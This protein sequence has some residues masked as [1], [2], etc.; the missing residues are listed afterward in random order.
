[1][2]KI[3]MTQEGLDK[4]VQELN[5]LKRI[6]RPDVVAAIK[7]ARE[8]GDLSENAEYHAARE[9]QAFI[10]GRIKELEVKTSI[11]EVIHIEDL[12]GDDIKFGAS[13]TLLDE[14]TDKKILYKIVGEEEASITAGLLS[15]VSPLARALI[16]KKKGQ[17][18]EVKT[19]RGEK[20]Y[21]ILNVEY[22]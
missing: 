18:I 11:A 21:E 8:L 10:E 17:G 19:P 20:Y 9:R 16:G 7:Q 5:T 3:P 12:K 22:K 6:E 15:I 13:I 4:L 14:E 2:K 1:M